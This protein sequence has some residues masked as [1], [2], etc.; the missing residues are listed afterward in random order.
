M[1][2][3][4]IISAVGILLAAVLLVTAAGS[5][6]F[7]TSSGTRWFLE[8]AAAHSTAFAFE[9]VAGHLTGNLR[10]DGLRV[11]LP[12]G[13]LRIGEVLLENRLAF[14][15]PLDWRVRTL[16]IQDLKLDLAQ[17]SAPEPGRGFAWPAI[18]ELPGWLRLT[19][20]QLSVGPLQVSRSGQPLYKVQDVTGRLEAGDGELRLSAFKARNPQTRLRGE[21]ILGS[22]PRRLS[23]QLSGE[24][25][26]A[27]GSAAAHLTLDLGPQPN[28]RGFA[29]PVALELHYPT[30]LQLGATFNLSTTAQGVRFSALKLQQEGRTGVISGSGR[31]QFAGSP[32]ADLNLRLQGLD[33][34]RETGRALQVSGDLSVSGRP[35]DYQ[36]R[37]ALQTAGDRLLQGRI[38][39]AL[40]GDLQH[41]ELEDLQGSWRNAGVAGQGRFGWA[42]HPRLTLQMQVSEIDP[43]PWHDALRGLLNADFEVSFEV[44]PQA[45]WHG[46]VD[47]VLK[48]SR[49]Q[50]YA[51]EGRSRVRFA[52]DRVVLESLQLAG[53]GMHLSASGNPREQLDFDLQIAH[54]ER[55][56]A[57]A[58]GSLQGRGQLRLTAAGVPVGEFVLHGERLAYDAWRLE[59]V[60][61]QGQL[62]VSPDNWTGELSAEGLAHASG[63]I[64]EVETL[65]LRVTGGPAA[66]RLELRAAA[67]GG[68]LS[69][70]VKGEWQDKRWQGRLSSVR[71][72]DPRFGPWTLAAAVPLRLSS[73]GLSMGTAL[74]RNTRD[75]QLRLSGGYQSKTGQLGLSAGWRNLDLEL[76]RPWLTADVTASGITTGQ[77]HLERDE[78]VR[79]Q[80]NVELTGKVMADSWPQDAVQRVAASLAW[81][82]NGLQA[83]LRLD[84]E[85]GAQ[86]ALRLTSPD[87]PERFPRLENADL[88]WTLSR[89]P[90]RLAE[91]WLPAGMTV[92]ADIS[93][94]GTVQWRGGRLLGMRGQLES[95]GGRLSGEDAHGVLTA[96]LRVAEIAWTW[97]ENLQLNARLDLLEG[98]DLEARLQIA[99]SAV[100]P[101]PELGPQA[102]SGSLNARLQ[103]RNLVA[104]LFPGW[105]SDSRADIALDLELGGRIEGPE[106]DGDLR[107]TN[108]SV[109][110]PEA[111]V[112][113]QNIHVTGKLQGRRLSLSRIELDSGEGHLSGT[114]RVDFS[115]WVPERAEFELSGRDVLLADI[116]GLQMVAAPDVQ[117][118]YQ[119]QRLE[120][121]GTLNLSEALYRGRETP[122]LAANSPDLVIVDSGRDAPPPT[123][124]TT[125]LDLQIVLGDQVLV[126][127]SG[128]DARLAGE[129]RILADDLQRLQAT[130]DIRV[131]K[132]RFSRYGVTLD[133]EQGVIVFSGGAPEQ[134]A[135]DILALRGLADEDLRVGVR[136]TGTPQNPQVTLYSEPAMS[137]TDILAYI[138]LGRPLDSGSGEDTDLLLTAA[139][140]LLSQGES[141][142]LQEQVKGR[143]GL[144][145][146]QFSAGSGDLDEARLVTGKYLTPDLYVSLGYSLFK[147]TNRFRIRYSLAPRWDIESQ[148]GQESGVD[149]FYRFELR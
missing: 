91:S 74:L 7:M 22:R 1:V 147:R 76:L 140:S 42:A 57:G 47:L 96:T 105:L 40:Q 59:A 119:K 149:L 48:D 95:A 49:L 133:I 130:G 16:R 148:V 77:L 73:D 127:H 28:A 27:E 39:G 123:A 132:G 116:P 45:G 61:G 98:G 121:R 134:A 124:F 17:T 69:A 43:R 5:W 54:L 135:L 23:G 110:L 51:L 24:L 12:G 60:R 145:V 143:L 111:G 141:A 85:S 100:W 75:A 41:L 25:D 65:H 64:P 101:F 15:V 114:G 46:Q 102:I 138:V 142:T 13:T 144:D 78:Q 38:T 66:H 146:L 21:L 103:E 62:P 8:R 131:V 115:G 67:G 31:V 137:D 120:I 20:A 11:T 122:R 71:F 88:S 36:G 99:Q 29:G 33:L 93:G 81:Q 14:A 139:G 84:G 79:F 113:L 80:A 94:S 34:T 117:L 63:R 104:N 32:L 30:A 112:E 70:Q 82:E 19:I 126:K 52:P 72:N 87:A 118:N 97:Q 18:P 35:A 55:L 2:K 83:D 56:L 106:W 68:Q 6:I 136:I 37:F 107:L 53:E 4:A 128:L 3:R 44:P 9:R 108:G 129:V 58:E 86:L 92:R 26:L 125:A 90:A 10:I 109:S 89:L 50:G